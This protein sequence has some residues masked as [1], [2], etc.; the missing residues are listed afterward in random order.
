MSDVFNP[1][2]FQ[3]ILIEGA[4]ETNRTPVPEGEY[5]SLIEGVRVKSVLI[6]KGEHAGESRAVLE[7]MY[8]LE[9]EEL[10]KKLNIDKPMIRQDIWL[11][12][13]KNAEGGTSLA[14]GPNTNIGLGRL[15]DATGLNKPNK[16]FGFQMLEGQPCKVVVTH[17]QV[18]DMVYDR[19]SKVMARG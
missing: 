16:P 17:D 11:D 13:T 10:K 8:A 9:D 14:F 1:E 2:E 3:N 7:V 18:D 4:N 5:E 19:V 12:T 15:R 6:R